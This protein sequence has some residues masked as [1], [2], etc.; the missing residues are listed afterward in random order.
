MSGCALF[1]L[2]CI[3]PMTSCRAGWIFHPS[4]SSGSFGSSKQAAPCMQARITL[5]HLFY[6]GIDDF[7]LILSGMDIYGYEQSIVHSQ[8]TC[9]TVAY[10]FTVVTLLC[11]IYEIVSRSLIL[12]DYSFMLLG[13]EIQSCILQQEVTIL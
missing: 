12:L 8:S 10:N 2:A 4:I 9:Y 5:A 7:D 11:H 13:N 6:L 1:L 3:H